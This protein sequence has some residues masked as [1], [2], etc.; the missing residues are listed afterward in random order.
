[1][2][3]SYSL[4]E[5]NEYVRRVISLNFPEPIWVNCEISQI[6]EVKGNVYLDLIYHNEDTGEITAQISANI[7]YKSFL[8]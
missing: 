5:L 4:F 2:R 7:W 6:K 8:F 3:Q 1:M